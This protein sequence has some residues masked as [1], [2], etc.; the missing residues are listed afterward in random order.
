MK[1]AQELVEEEY[2]RNYENLDV[3]ESPKVAEVKEVIDKACFLL[4]R[5]IVL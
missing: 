5:S 2:E 1:T 3:A 4:Q